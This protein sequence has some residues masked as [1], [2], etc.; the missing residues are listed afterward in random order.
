MWGRAL[1]N[2]KHMEVMSLGMSVKGSLTHLGS[3]ASLALP[4]TDAESQL[5]LLY[6]QPDSLPTSL[7]F[8]YLTC[9]INI[10][11]GSLARL[12]CTVTKVAKRLCCTVA[13]SV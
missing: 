7:R 6:I 12:C 4:R 8:L 11:L 1:P 13:C 5:D 2:L 9:F 10:P 3:L